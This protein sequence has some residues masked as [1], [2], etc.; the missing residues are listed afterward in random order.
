MALWDVENEGRD[1]AIR[2]PPPLFIV[3]TKLIAVPPLFRFHMFYPLWTLPQ[4]REVDKASAMLFV[5]QRNRVLERLGVRARWRFPL[6]PGLTSWHAIFWLKLVT[7]LSGV[8]C[9]QHCLS[10][11]VFKVNPIKVAQSDFTFRP[12]DR[13]AWPWSTLQ[14]IQPRATLASYLMWDKC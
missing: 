7:F 5:N 13:W 2:E 4:L 1:V 3:L 12:V 10:V 6:C 8:S 9:K 11:R 14:K